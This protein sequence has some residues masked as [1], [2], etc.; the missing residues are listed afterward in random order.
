MPRILAVTFV[1]VFSMTAA[2][3]LWSQEKQATEDASKSSD[4]S[5]RKLLERY[6][7]ANSPEV[8]SVLPD[9][10]AFDSNG[11]EFRFSELKGQYSVLVFG[12][13]T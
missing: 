3:Q 9:V 1:F 13:L 2:T 10:R 6:F 5:P 8:G 7:N 12:C 4:D 11:E